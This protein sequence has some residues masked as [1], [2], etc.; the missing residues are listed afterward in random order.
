MNQHRASHW[1]SR[2][3]LLRRAVRAI[4]KS[5]GRKP[6]ALL[7]RIVWMKEQVIPK[8]YLPLTQCAADNQHAPLGLLL[9]TILARINAAVAAALPTTEED[10]RPIAGHAPEQ[11]PSQPAMAG[12]QEKGELISRDALDLH[13]KTT[14]RQMSKA[15]SSGFNKVQKMTKA[16]EEPRAQLVKK[17]KKAKGD[18]FASMFDSI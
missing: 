7:P 12:A 9:V 13:G 18:D 5:P 8:T 14:F 10:L 4:V 2:F 11:P 16:R 3:A 6:E 1:W 15:T 17:K